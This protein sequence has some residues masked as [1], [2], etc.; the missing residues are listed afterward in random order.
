MN[1]LKLS[2]TLAVSSLLLLGGCSPT[3]DSASSK[4]ESLISQKPNVLVIMADDLGYND[5]GF[6]GSKHIKTPNLDELAENGMTFSD[7]YVTASVCSP[8]RAGFLTSRYQQRFGHEANVPPYGFGMDVNEFTSGQAFKSKGYKTFMIGKW[9]LGDTEAMY[10]TNRGFDEFWGLREGSRSYYHNKRDDQAGNFHAI[11]SNG[12]LAKFEGHLTGSMTDKAI[13]MI[14]STDDP[15]YMFLSYTAPHG[16]LQADPEDL[17]KANNDPY[18]ALVQDMD[19]HIGRLL[20]YL[21]ETGKRDN[22]IIW[23]LSDNGGTKINASNYPLNGKKGIKFEGGVRVPMVLNWPKKIDSSTV[24]DGLVSSMDIL[25]TSLALAGLSVDFPKP[26]DGVDLTPY[27]LEKNTEAAPRTELYWRKLEGKAMRD[28]NW[29][30]IK[31][32]G[33]DPML[34]NLADDISERK[35]LAEAH[36]QLVQE[37][38]KKLETWEG[39]LMQPLW[40]EGDKWIAV[41]KSEYIRFRDATDFVPLEVKKVKKKNKK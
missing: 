10:P 15:F 2:L 31:T 23:F 14:G 37:M 12:E 39:D 16:P 17:A 24:V 28:G 26:L 41:R 19:E 40:K 11:E 13:E 8:S 4:V 36:P 6:Q 21:Q 33:L 18:V 32:E 1:N 30:I 22:T 20:N 7:A 3:Q 34:Y 25:P 29:K 5:L 38:L 35:N 27:L 9:H